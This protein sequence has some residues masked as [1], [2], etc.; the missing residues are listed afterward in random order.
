MRGRLI[1]TALLAAVLIL[2]SCGEEKREPALLDSMPAG[3][4]VYTL[5][6]LIVGVL[7]SG[8]PRK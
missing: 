8:S 7:V 1:S 2:A 3:Y 5:P 6:L 4:E